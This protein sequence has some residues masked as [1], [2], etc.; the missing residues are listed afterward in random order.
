MCFYRIRK[1]LYLLNDQFKRV[2]TTIRYCKI[3]KSNC[4]IDF[5]F[6]N[7]IENVKT[8]NIRRDRFVNKTLRAQCSTRIHDEQIDK[9]RKKQVLSSFCVNSYHHFR[10]RCFRLRFKFRFDKTF[11][12]LN[13]FFKLYVFFYHDRKSKILGIK[14]IQK[15][16]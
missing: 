8:I 12:A 11:K 9:C 6:Y 14:N 10:D 5:L 15:K 16:S 7:H 1:K 2:N 13:L 3:N 4:F